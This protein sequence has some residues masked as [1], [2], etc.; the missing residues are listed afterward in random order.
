MQFPVQDSS[1]IGFA[2]GFY[3]SLALGLSIDEAVHA[4]R[5]AVAQADDARGWATPVL[6]LRSPDGAIF[7]EFRDDPALDYERSAATIRARLTFESL[8]GSGTVADIGTMRSGSIDAKAQGK[9]VAA[10][11]T[12]DVLAIDK[13]V[14]GQ[15]G[16]DAH[17]DEVKGTVTTVTIADLNPGQTSLWP[18]SRP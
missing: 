6:H 15:V 10:G 13:L 5:V 11:G 4:G 2:T 18:G 14:G 1:A 9:V 7:T 17:I 3:G 8:T 12:L 16:A